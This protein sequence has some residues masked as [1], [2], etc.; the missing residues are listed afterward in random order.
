M[1]IREDEFAEEPEL[2]MAPLLDVVLQL[3]IF[4]LVATSWA[5]EEERLDLELP[6]AHNGA[7]DA[8]E[9]REIVIEV[10]RDG[11]TYLGGLEVRAADLPGALRS[12]SG[13]DPEHPV[14]VRGDRLASHE[15]IVAVL[16]ACGSAGLRD[17]AVATLETAGEQ[18]R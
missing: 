3:L 6:A 10:L 5:R 12:A 1:R 13:G 9:R 8:A 17:L 14:T 4:F 15:S 18:G 7:S 16:D 2:L 11:R